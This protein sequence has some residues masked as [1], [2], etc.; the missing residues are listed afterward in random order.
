M[1]GIATHIKDMAARFIDNLMNNIL[2][3]FEQDVLEQL[4]N[5]DVDLNDRYQLLCKIKD[6]ALDKFEK[7]EQSLY[8]THHAAFGPAQNACIRA[9]TLW[10]SE[11]FKSVSSDMSTKLNDTLIK[12][13]CMEHLKLQA[14]DK[15][16]ET[17]TRITQAT[18]KLDGIANKL[19]RIHNIANILSGNTESNDE[20]SAQAAI[21]DRPIR[22]PN[23]LDIIDA[24]LNQICDKLTQIS[25]RP[26]QATGATEQVIY[27]IADIVAS[28]WRDA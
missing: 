7:L 20:A 22:G 1:T 16:N 27:R 21:V 9:Y 23:A 18:D 25:G 14:S 6:E 12:I 4:K 11:K 17:N 2:K 24:R 8:N 26:R 10:I 28:F 19:H 13:L 5:A 3:D 15:A